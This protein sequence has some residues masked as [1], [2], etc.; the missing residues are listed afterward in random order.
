MVS[1]CDGDY[2][3]ERR[4]SLLWQ[5]PVIDGA[6][7]SGSMEFSCGG[8]ADD[9]F[10]V[11]VTFYSKKPYSEIKVSF[12]VDPPPSSF[13]PLLCVLFSNPLRAG[14]GLLRGGGRGARQ[15]QLGESLHHRQV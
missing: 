12:A 1:E 4:G 11:R 8:N 14:A 5:L 3:Y 10:P 2:T 7:R 6:N 15:V 9:F 13:P